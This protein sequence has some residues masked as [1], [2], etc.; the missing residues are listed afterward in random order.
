MQI[1]QYV[2]EVHTASPDHFAPP[3]FI[4]SFLNGRKLNEKSRPFQDGSFS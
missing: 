3:W 2:L 1:C 4:I